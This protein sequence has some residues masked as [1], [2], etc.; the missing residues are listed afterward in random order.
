MNALD[1]AVTAQPI[2]LSGLAR[3][4]DLPPMKMRRVADGTSSVSSTVAARIAAILKEPVDDLFYEH[5]VNGGWYARPIEIAA[6]VA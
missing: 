1:R 2:N 4:V 5:P 3:Q 6:G